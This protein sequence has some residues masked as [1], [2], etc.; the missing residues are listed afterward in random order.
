MSGVFEP[1]QHPV[2]LM[3][4]WHNSRELMPNGS[5][6]QGSEPTANSSSLFK[7]R[8][9]KVPSPQNHLGGKVIMRLQAKNKWKRRDDFQ[10]EKESK[11]TAVTDLTT[12]CF[13]SEIEALAVYRDWTTYDRSTCYL[14]GLNGASNTCKYMQSLYSRRIKYTKMSICTLTVNLKKNH[15][16][17][18][19][20]SILVTLKQYCDISLN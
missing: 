4:V 6:P 8:T 16:S 14:S 7:T 5:F 9:K 2:T 19:R 13:R 18:W 10:R 11:Q 20:I 3:S 12:S 1:S 15:Y 17:C